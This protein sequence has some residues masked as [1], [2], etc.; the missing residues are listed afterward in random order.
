MTNTWR[1]WL[2]KGGAMIT[3][4]CVW[5]LL[6][7]LAFGQIVPAPSSG[8]SNPVIQFQANGF[9]YQYDLSGRSTNFYD[10]GSGMTGYMSKDANGLITAQGTLY[11]PIPR[12]L[13]P[14]SSESLTAPPPHSPRSQSR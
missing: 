11:Q 6:A 9:G 8:P 3:G 4:L 13:H 1:A 10:L 5:I 7:Q 14:P 2:W 12:V